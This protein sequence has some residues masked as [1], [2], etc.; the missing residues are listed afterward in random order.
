[1]SG[2]HV[3]LLVRASVVKTGVEKKGYTFGKRVAPATLFFGFGL[4]KGDTGVGA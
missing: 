1:M 4:Q 2:T 3:R